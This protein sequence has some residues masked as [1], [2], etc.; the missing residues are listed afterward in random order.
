MD[1]P[2]TIF[3]H[4]PCMDGTTAAWAAYQKWGDSVEYVGLDHAAYEKT[5]ATILEHV[6]PETIAVFLDFAPRTQILENILDKVAGVEVF[7][8]HIS[9]ENDLQPFQGHPK[10]H[11]Y[12]DMTR[13]GAGIVYDEF[14]NLAARPLFIELVERIDLYKPERF[15]SP[16]QFYLVSS[17]LSSL[18]VDKPFKQMLPVINELAAIDDI[19]VFE[20]RGHQPRNAYL[21]KVSDVLSDVDFVNMTVLASASGCHEVPTAQTNINDMG[22]EFSPKLLALCPGSACMG[23]VW[24]FYDSQTIKVSLR[25][26]GQIDVSQ[27][28]EEMGER[29]GINGGGH[30]GAAAARFTIE[31]FKDFAARI[32]LPFNSIPPEA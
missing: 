25:S 6:T 7:D 26:N 17:Y 19:N 20:T 14:S 21:E 2:R 27:I 5:Q 11:I 29:F 3:Y 30:K 9:A 24:E 16:E 8:H 22:H 31:Q 12:F 4:H 13:S 10:C 15:E 32:H 28:A 23:M 1:Q 18:D